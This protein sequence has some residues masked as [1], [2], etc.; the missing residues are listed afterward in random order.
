MILAL[1]L[2][3]TNFLTNLRNELRTLIQLPGTPVVLE[4][5]IAYID[6]IV[7]EKNTTM[8][9][10]A[11]D[12]KNT[13]GLPTIDNQNQKHP[14][15]N[16]DAVIHIDQPVTVR[17]YTFDLIPRSSSTTAITRSRDDRDGQAVD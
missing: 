16:L 5:A 3:S 17:S 2:N 14:T 10:A 6:A 7:V 11:P 4:G 15:A 9:V 12:P 8:A 1:Q 13:R